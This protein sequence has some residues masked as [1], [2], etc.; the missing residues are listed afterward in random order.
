[1]KHQRDFSRRDFIRAASLASAAA[2]AGENTAWSGLDT[3]GFLPPI[4]V[5]SKVFQ[6]LKLDFEASAALTAEAGL[7]GIDCAVRPGGEILPERAKDEM[8]QYAAALKKHGS[9]M[10]LL[11]TGITGPASPHAE[12][13]LRAARQLDLRYYRLAYWYH[14]PGEDAGKLRAEIRATLKDL[15][16]FNRELGVCAV[17]QN[18]SADKGANPPAGADLVELYDLVKD[19]DPNEVGVAFDLGHAIIMHGDDWPAHF[20]RLKDHL[21]VAYVKDVRRPSSFVP[22]GQGEFS[23]TDFFPRLRALGYHAPL[24]MHLEYE[25]AAKDQKTRPRLLEALTNSRQVLGQ[26]L[27]AAG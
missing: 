17:F 25:W 11:T 8:P 21:R 6:E 3:T 18:H 14:R 27:K 19:L 4:A 1:M 23:R 9:R 7:D 2:L 20:E 16:A 10:L 12:S 5:F 22:F 15:A 26:W 13:V 24:S